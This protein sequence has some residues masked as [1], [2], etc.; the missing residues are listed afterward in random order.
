MR[1]VAAR[2]PPDP[3]RC[4]Q[5]RVRRC[6]AARPM[7]L[8]QVLGIRSQ[9]TLFANEVGDGFAC[10]FGCHQPKAPS[11]RELSAK[12]TEG[13]GAALRLFLEIS[14]HRNAIIP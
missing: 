12:L 9:L 8:S 11:P 2:G 1:C 4:S 3:R 6:L 7:V 5:Y 10:A 13:V 14:Q